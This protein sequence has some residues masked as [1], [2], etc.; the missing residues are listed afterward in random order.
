MEKFRNI[1][2]TGLT[3][4]RV[5]SKGLVKTPNGRIRR[6]EIYDYNGAKIK[7][8]RFPEIPGFG[9]INVKVL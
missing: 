9:L 1:N 4:F 8:M 6:P 5:N 2:I 7:V 3:N